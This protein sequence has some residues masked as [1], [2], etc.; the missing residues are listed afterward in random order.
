[1]YQQTSPDSSSHDV[2][3]LVSEQKNDR[4][5]HFQQLH[6]EDSFGGSKSTRV[7]ELEAVDS[8][9]F[10]DKGALPSHFHQI[11][12]PI[13]SILRPALHFCNL[14][15]RIILKNIRNENSQTVIPHIESNVPTNPDLHRDES[16]LN[17]ASMDKA[18]D[19]IVDDLSK[20][21]EDLYVSFLVVS[22][23]FAGLVRLE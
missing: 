18:V 1:M 9:S 7:P 13:W 11:F 5:T 19:D 21:C 8:R 22:F 2:S 14:F 15:L 17:L 12:Q 23:V 4:Q 20:S 10:I 6:R 3:K 16:G